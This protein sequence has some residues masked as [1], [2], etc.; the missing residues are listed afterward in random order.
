MVVNASSS[1]LSSS[2]IQCTKRRGLKKSGHD[3]DDGYDCKKKVKVKV[4]CIGRYCSLFFS[5]H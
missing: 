1:S 5:N 3:H 2:L 4:V